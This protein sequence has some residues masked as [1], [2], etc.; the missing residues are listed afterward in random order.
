MSLID[1]IYLSLPVQSNG[2][3]VTSDVTDRVV[4]DSDA[5]S[6]DGEEFCDTSD[7]TGLTVGYTFTVGAV[8]Y[9][10]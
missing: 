4:A 1:N 8:F 10:R 3:G 9:V 5:L 2:I 7:V 6:S